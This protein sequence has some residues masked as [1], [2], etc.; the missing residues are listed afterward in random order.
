VPFWRADFLCLAKARHAVRYPNAAFRAAIA[1]TCPCGNPDRGVHRPPEKL[2][3]NKRFANGA[4]AEIDL[5]FGFDLPPL[6]VRSEEFEIQSLAA[7]QRNG[8]TNLSRPHTCSR[9]AAPTV[10][11]AHTHRRKMT[12]QQPNL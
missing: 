3:H 9:N 10:A 6:V 2:A 4:G 1:D 8:A 7:N 11:V 12:D 5:A